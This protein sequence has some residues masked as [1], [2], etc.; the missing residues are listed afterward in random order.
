MSKAIEPLF[1]LTRIRKGADV[2]PPGALYFP[3][4]ETERER[5][6]GLAAGR[7]PTD[8]ERGVLVEGKPRPSGLDLDDKDGPGGSIDALDKLK[9]P[10]LKALAAREGID[11][12]DATKSNEIKAAIRQARAEKAAAEDDPR[13]E[14][15]SDEESSGDGGLLEA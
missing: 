7:D 15:S 12:G 14:T 11:L 6:I 4:S 13:V 8:I 1:A 9:V 5:L 10:D 2:C 3:I